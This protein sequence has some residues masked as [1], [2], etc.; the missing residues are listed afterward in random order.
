MPPLTGAS[1]QSSLPV[2]SSG[3]S[4]L[5]V[6]KELAYAAGGHLMKRL[7]TP[8]DVQEKSPGNLVTDVDR[9]VEALVMDRLRQEFHGVGILAE[10]S[11]VHEGNSEWSWIIDPLDGTRNYASGVPIFAVTL[12]LARGPEVLIG[13]TYDPNRDELFYA[14][15]GE[16][17]FLN[18]TQIRVAEKNKFQGVVVGTD[19][20]YDAEKGS[21]VLEV[22]DRLWPANNGILII[23]SAALGLAYAAIGRTDIYFHHLLW[24]WDIAAGVLLGQESGAVITNGGGEEID[25]RR[26]RS[27]VLANPAIHAQF[28]DL[29]DGLPWRGS[30]GSPQ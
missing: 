28:L 16:G 19:M 23:G 12:A 27:I 20:G 30:S 6:A 15:K 10:E 22:L 21:H 9:E 24:P 7:H 3:K 25:Y 17:A 29:S 14:V 18:G 1:L 13:V 11:G 5:A 4:V 8:K 26:D 2:A